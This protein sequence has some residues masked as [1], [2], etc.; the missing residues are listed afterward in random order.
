PWDGFTTQYG[1]W[2][3]INSADFDALDIAFY[4]GNGAGI[5]GADGLDVGIGVFS[6]GP[7]CS[8]L[9][10]VIGG[11]GFDSNPND[12]S[13]LDGFEFNSYEFGI[14]ITPNTNYYLCL[15]TSNPQLCGNFSLN[16]SLA[17]VGCTDLAACNYDAGASINDGTCEY[18]SCAPSVE[19][20]LCINAISLVCDASINGSTGAS[21]AAGAPTVCPAGSGDNGVWYTYAG[22]GQFVTLSTCGSDIDSRINVLTSSGGCNG[23]F[24]CEVSADDDATNCGFFDADDATVEFV[25]EAGT[26]YYIYITAGGVDTDGDFVDDLFDGSFVL[27]TTCDPVVEGCTDD[28]AC[29]YLPEANIENN[30]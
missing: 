12:G 27:N 26:T 16:V 22:D 2:Y 28:C 9:T 15:T 14:T 6:G 19:N 24:A 8:N 23:V 29:N 18:T 10:P 21:T 3:Q 30:N 1:I 20:D 4:N 25:A 5:D 13:T 7:D 11:I 17:N